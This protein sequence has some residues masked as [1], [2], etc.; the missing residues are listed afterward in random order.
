MKNSRTRGI[1]TLAALALVVVLAAMFVACDPFYYRPEGKGIEVVYHI[2]DGTDAT[3]VEQDV[4]LTEVDKKYTPDEREGYVFKG[5]ALED[6]SAFLAGS[7]KGEKAELYAQWER[8]SY[9]VTF[10]F[11]SQNDGI[12][13]RVLHGDAA[14]LPTD[15]EIAPYLPANTYL[16]GWEDENGELID[17]NDLKNIT[18]NVTYTARV[19]T[20]KITVEFYLNKGD[21][22]PFDSK[23]GDPGDPISPMED[24][25]K[26]LP[27]NPGFDF[28][29][30]YTEEGELLEDFTF[31]KNAKYY[32]TYALTV[33]AAPQFDAEDD[34][35]FAT[36]GDPLAISVI[37][38]P[39]PAE[40]IVYTYEWYTADF[41]EDGKQ[42][43]LEELKLGTGATLD[44]GKLVVGNYTF[45]VRL[46]ASSQGYD[47]AASDDNLI[48]AI[49]SKAPL[50]VK[51]PKLTVTYGDRLPILSSV[52]LTFEGFKHDDDASAVSTN[53]AILGSDNYVAGYGVGEYSYFVNGLRAD[54]YDFRGENGAELKGVVSV[55]AKNLT[56]KA[57]RDFLLPFGSPENN[58]ELTEFESVEG[59]LT[60]HGHTVFVTLTLTGTTPRT[61]HIG[62][63]LEE[64]VVVKASDGEIVT[65]NYNITVYATAI[66]NLG[67]IVYVEPKNESFVYDGE[68]HGFEVTVA[69]EACVP[70]YRVVKK[71]DPVGQTE[72][73]PDIPTVTNAGTYQI[74]YLL[75][76][77]NYERVENSFE[78]T[79][80]PA[81]LKVV[82]AEQSATYG[83]AFALDESKFSL[84]AE[85][86]QI[87][88]ELAESLNIH[89]S[90]DYVSGDPA[91]EYVINIV[92]ADDPNV[93]FS[94]TTN[95]LYVGKADI[96]LELNDL[97]LSYGD[98]FDASK[99]FTVIGTP[100][101]GA[102]PTVSVETEYA[103][104]KPAG[105]TFA[106]KV[107]LDEASLKNYAATI[108]GDCSI[109]V[110]KR[111]VS[112]TVNSA[113][114]IFGDPAPS[115]DFGFTLD[116][117]SEMF[118]EEAL[119]FDFETDYERGFGASM[120]YSVIATLKENDVN[121]NYN[122]SVKNGSLTV[123]KRPVRLKVND[124][125]ATYGEAISLAFTYSLLDDTSFY[126][127]SPVPSY[128]TDYIP[129][130]TSGVIDAEFEDPNHD[131]TV[132]N[133]SV[134]VRQRP[135]TIT[136]SGVHAANGDPYKHV[137][138][139]DDNSVN[140]LYSTDLLTGT[141]A[142]NDSATNTYTG[143]EMFKWLDD[144]PLSIKNSSETEVKDFYAITYLL[145][146][147]ISEDLIGFNTNAFSG[148]YDG[149]KH[150]GQVEVIDK[151]LQN[152]TYEY[153][154]TEDGDYKSELIEFTD[155]GDHRVYFRITADDKT[156]T[157]GNFIVRI[158]K[159]PATLTANNAN[160]TF[161]DD[162]PEYGY[163][164]NNVLSQDIASLNVRV[165]GA[166]QKGNDV[167]PA[168]YAINVGYDENHNY[169]ITTV[170]GK[171]TV[172]PKAVKLTLKQQPSI[173]Y[174]EEPST[175]QYGEFDADFEGSHE[176][177]A[178]RTEYRRGN[179][180]GEY[181]ILATGSPNFAYTVVTKLSIVARKATITLAPLSATYGTD[182]ISGMREKLTAN[183]FYGNDFAAIRQSVSFLYNDA[184]FTNDGK[185]VGTYY[186]VKPSVSAQNYDITC[187]AGDLTV[188]KANLTLSLTALQQITYGDTYNY[189]VV[190]AS[191]LAACDGQDWTKVVQGTFAALICKSG[192]KDP[193][194]G[195]LTVGVYDVI[196]SG[197]TAKNYEVSYAPRKL[198]VNKATLTATVDQL[199][200]AVKYNSDIPAFTYSVTGY[201]YDDASSVR[202]PE[203]A[204]AIKTDYTKGK[205]ANTTCKYYVEIDPSA[206]LDNYV[207][208]AGPQSSFKIAK[209]DPVRMSYSGTATGTYSKGITLASIKLTTGF[210]WKTSSTKIDCNTKSAEA[211][212]NP[213]TLNY[214]DY[215]LTIDISVAKATLTL[216]QSSSISNDT[217]SKDWTN[218]AFNIINTFGFSLPSTYDGGQKISYTTDGKADF[219]PSDGGV[220]TVV[221]TVPGSTNWNAFSKTYTFKIKAAK[222]GSTTYTLEDALSTGGTITLIGNAF[223]SKSAE[224]KSGSTLNLPY[225]G[226]NLTG[227]GETGKGATGF[228]IDVLN[229][230]TY[231][232]LLL[233]IRSGV[234]LTVSGTMNVGG[235]TGINNGAYYQGST[236]SYYA[237]VHL[238][239]TATIDLNG[240]LDL[241][242][243]ITSANSSAK[244]NVNN[245]STLKAPFVVHDYRGGSFTGGA[246]KAGSISPFNQY[247]MPNI[248]N[249]TQTIKSGATV[250][251]YVSLRTEDTD[252]KIGV[253]PASYN[254]AETTIVAS[255]NAMINL[256][257][258]SMQVIHTPS[259]GKETT[260]KTKI[261]LN[262]SSSASIGSLY[263]KLDLHV[264]GINLDV[265]VD[266]STV[267][268][269]IPYNY[270]ITI[271]NAATL[272][273]PNK[274]K[275]LPGSKITVNSGGTLDLT[276]GGL[277]V[278][279]GNWK[280]VWGS[281]NDQRLYPTGKGAAQIIV[282]GT[283]K[284]G[285]A[286]GGTITGGTN[287]TVVVKTSTLSVA[288]KEGTGTLD[289]SDYMGLLFGNA[290][291]FTANYTQTYAA[292]LNGYSGSLANGSTYKYSGGKWTKS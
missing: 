134:N 50:T 233:T 94:I 209:A 93:E 77:E 13:R 162:A 161:G 250:I 261:T 217:L 69:T 210:R 63:G 116:E 68:K 171:L 165:T 104:G 28:K 269:P 283:F 239:G 128:T 259:V 258:G 185:D 266:T 203:N 52:A 3:H 8:R 100:E 17:E 136:L 71:D 31:Q 199:K 114:V 121:S 66:I 39:S 265:E 155:A 44:P 37:E 32:A 190:S 30:W 143:I 213:N 138:V 109:S 131:V 253:I 273:I 45:C 80:S 175:V 167:I 23:T 195:N 151:N 201:K 51:L 61:Y 9:D 287:G 140:N 54:N 53:Y 147:S 262:A 20:S 251:A 56:I 231:Q 278:Y 124:V 225:D 112:V 129:G 33:P 158:T 183:N 21:D 207:I 49:V 279:D 276:G 89:A 282:N 123:S 174:G 241:H 78:V 205:N 218:N 107:K 25:I 248:Q 35:V 184:P 47:D 186:S 90:T 153:C 227:D 214:E 242:G 211:Y 24:P 249:I 216:T 81:M 42:N 102:L 166:Y 220:Y 70:K 108:F 58:F 169:T 36:Y 125:D 229:T 19:R 191:G 272:T 260:N 160:A 164:P 154:L 86:G 196:G 127:V 168:G 92:H 106:V 182:L 180:V 159:R 111:D 232:K 236:S 146:I 285:A 281:V 14:K 197:Y 133:G 22:E 29:G 55:S 202:I 12:V 65:Q 41:T 72:Y 130:S 263:M 268:F 57:K 290:Y 226:T 141:L 118:G 246:Y 192:T 267:Y 204:I 157:P 132:E 255:S 18:S 101:N 11:P 257:S 76:L 73:L 223:L 43:H 2:N 88:T 117:G 163:T 194:Q 83:Y 60:D 291:K 126:G 120:T 228:N 5:W 84:S 238:E 280:D 198:T 4:K 219:N 149:Q 240:T 103:A 85:T 264:S 110:R 150:S 206:T 16:V 113:N 247:E 48:T 27:E 237:R 97:T 271:S 87:P 67:H 115:E 235:I 288:A 10:K 64:T 15:E 91:G 6:G 95:K 254:K 270:D 62:D 289:K 215:P 234:K 189:A 179:G 122:V 26:P 200:A 105:S 230:T 137:F 224:L 34:S 212:Y 152:V 187:V 156:P 40:N 46:V 292:S 252:V 286:F 144:S 170:A 284:V 243:F 79:V 142:T 119:T 7:F 148:M 172:D 1:L 221:V 74:F 59:L 38:V 177:V 99:A 208:V 245:G 188:E 96:S 256:T 98:E 139:K 173:Q 277:I 178:F 193:V 222:I 274:V 135:L 145:T 75:E 244:L 275:M 176:G 82:A 181:D